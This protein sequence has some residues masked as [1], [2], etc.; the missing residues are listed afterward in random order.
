MY[1]KIHL[2]ILAQSHFWTFVIWT[3]LRLHIQFKVSYTLK[4]ILHH[5]N[6]GEQLFKHIHINKFYAKYNTKKKYICNLIFVQYR[7]LLF[8]YGYNLN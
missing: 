7:L 5:A 3:L 8:P 1:I 4:P 6:N 2:Y